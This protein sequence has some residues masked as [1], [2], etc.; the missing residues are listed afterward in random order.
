M[1]ELVT[2]HHDKIRDALG[3]ICAM[4]HNEVVHE[5]VSRGAVDAEMVPALIA[6]LGMRRV[7]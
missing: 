2:Q 5:P 3:D 4:V 6:D 1:G 7:W